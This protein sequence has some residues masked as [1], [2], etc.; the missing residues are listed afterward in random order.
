M[1]NQ[2]KKYSIFQQIQKKKPTDITIFRCLLL[3]KKHN[4]GAFRE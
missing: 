3:Q 4:N 2:Y 1:D